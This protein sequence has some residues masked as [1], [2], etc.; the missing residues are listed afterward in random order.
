MAGHPQRFI[1]RRSQADAWFIKDQHDE[2]LV[3]IIQKGKRPQEKT[4]AMV[5]VMLD[6]LNAAVAPRTRAGEGN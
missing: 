6:A 4:Q 3:C 5:K 2:S 1:L